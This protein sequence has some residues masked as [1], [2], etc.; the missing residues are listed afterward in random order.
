ML[1]IC[2]INFARFETRKPAQTTS[3]GPN[4]I[5][6]KFQ[7]D[8]KHLIFFEKKIRPKNSDFLTHISI[9]LMSKSRIQSSGPISW[10]GARNFAS[11]GQSFIL[12]VLHQPELWSQ[13]HPGSFEK[14]IPVKNMQHCFDLCEP[15]FSVSWLGNLCKPLPNVLILHPESFRLSCKI[16]ICY[17]EKMAGEHPTNIK[18]MQESW[19]YCVSW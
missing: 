11:D 5:P 19:N 6:T 13:H 9:F 3:Q 16:I 12:Q 10:L 8:L 2:L 1:S 4:I 14:H 7:G 18:F 17:D 15:N